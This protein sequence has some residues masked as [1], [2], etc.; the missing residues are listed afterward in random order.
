MEK[1]KR[2]NSSDQGWQKLDSFIGQK[3]T[4]KPPA[5]AWQELALKLIDELDIP[6]FKK[7]AVF[8]IC[9]DYPKN[10][11]EQALID[12]KELCKSGAKWKYF[13]KIIAN[14]I[15]WDK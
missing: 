14:K 3:K 2:G 10:L 5:H 11:V 15:E 12:T 9:R 4:V 7:T 13:F 1:K 8:Q 6:P